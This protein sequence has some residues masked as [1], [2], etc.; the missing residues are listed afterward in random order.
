MCKLATFCVVLCFYGIVCGQEP[1]KTNQNKAIVYIYSRDAPMV[2]GTLKPPIFLDDKEIAKLPPQRFFIVIIDP[3][4]HSL[5]FK[6]SKKSGGVEMNFE[7]G[8]VYYLRVGWKAGFTVRPDGLDPVPEGVA[9]FDLKE[10][11]P[12]GEKDIKDS[13]LVFLIRPY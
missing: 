10:M 8:K 5:H 9:N 7:V 2:L 1:P 13:T 12:I 11:K 4:K 6:K 3:G